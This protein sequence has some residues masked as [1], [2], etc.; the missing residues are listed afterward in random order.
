EELR[1]G[2][3][4]GRQGETPFDASAVPLLPF[5]HPERPRPGDDHH[6]LSLAVDVPAALPFRLPRRQ[7]TVNPPALL[8]LAPV[9]QQPARRA[10]PGGAPDRPGSRPPGVAHAGP[11][12][13]AAAGPGRNPPAPAAGP[14]ART[15]PAPGPDASSASWPRRR[16]APA[17]RSG[18]YGGSGPRCDAT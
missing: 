4:Q 17:G 8:L 7:R 12:P 13:R 16:R 9:P 15:A 5:P 3:F 1:H 11:A 6:R 14:A 18:S 10:V 2:H